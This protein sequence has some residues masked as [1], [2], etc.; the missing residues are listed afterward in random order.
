MV[1]EGVDVAEVEVAALWGGVSRPRPIV[2][3][4]RACYASVTGCRR[5]VRSFEG[6]TRRASLR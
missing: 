1:G 2:A 3:R 6:S 5:I 4:D